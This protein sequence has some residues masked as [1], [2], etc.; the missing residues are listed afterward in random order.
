MKLLFLELSKMYRKGPILLL[1][2]TFCLFPIFIIIGNYFIIEQ[3]Q[4]PEGLIFETTQRVIL[5]FL[6]L[7]LTVPVWIIVFIGIEFTNGHVHKLTFYLSKKAYFISKLIWCSFVSFIF[8][9][10]GVLALF[11]SAKI[12]AL[13]VPYYFEGY[14]FFF[15]QCFL[16]IVSLTLLLMPLVIVVRNSLVSFGLYILWS[17]FDGTL[18]LLIAKLKFTTLFPPLHLTGIFYKR[19]NDKGDFEYCNLFT[20]EPHHYLLLLL[21]ILAAQLLSYWHFQRVSLKPLSD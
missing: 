10:L 15:F 19:I 5:D 8:S 2:S 9:I 17:F 11:V 12:N 6:K 14:L 13:L 1:V 20:Q 3:R 4:V 7:Y 18:A 16:S 21:F